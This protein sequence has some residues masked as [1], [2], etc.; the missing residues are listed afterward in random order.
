[1]CMCM[2]ICSACT[3]STSRIPHSTTTHAHIDIEHSTCQLEFSVFPPFVTKFGDAFA[4]RGKGSPP[5]EKR[6]EGANGSIS[7][8]A[9][10]LE[11]KFK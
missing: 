4:L 5:P 1:M 10:F 6:S 8:Y 2:C 11:F 9:F 3:R 7:V